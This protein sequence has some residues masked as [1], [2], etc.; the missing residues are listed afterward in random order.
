MGKKEWIDYLCP[1]CKRWLEATIDSDGVHK[2]YECGKT[3]VIVK[4][5]QCTICEKAIKRR[6]FVAGVKII[7]DDCK[8][9]FKI[10]S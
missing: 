2:C 5:L 4:S 9:E 1:H 6:N 8:R 3:N 10:G 7:C